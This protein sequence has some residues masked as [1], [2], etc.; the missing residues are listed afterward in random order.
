MKLFCKVFYFSFFVFS[1]NSCGVKPSQDSQLSQTFSDVNV[2]KEGVITAEQL[3][4]IN[5]GFSLYVKNGENEVDLREFIDAMKI[6]GPLK[7]KVPEILATREPTATLTCQDG[8]C[9]FVSLGDPYSFVADWI[10]VPLFGK[11]TIYLGPVIMAEVLVSQNGMR[12]E[13]CELS[14][15]RAKA[16]MLTATPDG[17]R[18]EIDGSEIKEFV[19]DTG[20]DGGTYPTEACNPG[21]AFPAPF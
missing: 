21:P 1:L 14:G 12:G 2:P 3:K 13:I 7:E 6:E 10:N 9:R 16:S 4:N 20:P 15:I 18:Y 11:P 8:R 19:M 17:L 5:F